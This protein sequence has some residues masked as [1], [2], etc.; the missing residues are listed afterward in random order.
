MGSA[1]GFFCACTDM[2]KQAKA[3]RNSIF[4]LMIDVI[5]LFEGIKNNR[6]GGKWA[7]KYTGG[8]YV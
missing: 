5:V 4:F 3:A 1:P 8:Q 6:S 7:V 2:E